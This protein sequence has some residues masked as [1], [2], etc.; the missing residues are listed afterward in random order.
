MQRIRLARLTDV[1]GQIGP[2]EGVQKGL[3]HRPAH[4]VRLRKRGERKKDGT[5]TG[6]GD[7]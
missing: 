4:K 5:L 7:R 6:N 3:E 1:W 2:G